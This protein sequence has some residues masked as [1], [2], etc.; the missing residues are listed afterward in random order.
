MEIPVA[1][2]PTVAA[3][4]PQAASQLPPPPPLP[5][6]LVEVRHLHRLFD[7]VHAVKDLNFN[8]HRGQVV[9]F[10]GANGAGKTTTMR[11]GRM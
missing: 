7:N 5:E 2:A 10:R 9:G 11:Q 6:T 1:A 8:I 4:A 3:P